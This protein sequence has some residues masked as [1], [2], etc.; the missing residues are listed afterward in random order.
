MKIIC[1]ETWHKIPKTWQSEHWNSKRKEGIDASMPI[2]SGITQ[3]SYSWKSMYPSKHTCFIQVIYNEPAGYVTSCSTHQSLGFFLNANCKKKQTWRKWSICY[4]IIIKVKTL[5][6]DEVSTSFTNNIFV[7]QYRKILVFNR[8][9]RHPRN[10]GKHTFH[11]I[12][13]LNLEGMG[14][15]TVLKMA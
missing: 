13:S 5:F 12:Q 6:G 14:R 11:Y 4:Y 8:M 2:F 7:W 3:S 10:Y 15:V 9:A 1:D